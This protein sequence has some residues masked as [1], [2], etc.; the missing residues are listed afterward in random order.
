MG[1]ESPRPAPPWAVT[2]TGL[3]R[4][5]DRARVRARES[6]STSRAEAQPT[7]P[8]KPAPSSHQIPLILVEKALLMMYGFFLLLF[9]Y[10]F[11]HANACHVFG[12]NLEKLASQTHLSRNLVLKR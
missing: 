8:L 10:F 12:R 2:V 4:K 1:Y 11:K 6:A 5:Q 3:S 9:I 7:V